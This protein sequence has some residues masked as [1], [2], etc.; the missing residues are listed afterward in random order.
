M[1]RLFEQ[2]KLITFDADDTLWDFAKML[3]RGTEAVAEAIARDHPEYAHLSTEAIIQVQ[4][5]AL[6][7][8]DP[9]TID[10]YNM[11][12]EAF[13]G[14]LHDCGHPTAAEYAHILLEAYLLARDSQYDFWPD[15][16]STLDALRGRFRL[17]YITNGT[18]HPDKVKL[19]DYFDVVVTPDTL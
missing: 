19:S 16:L 11:R 2:V 8:A 6:R 15:T 1:G 10:F 12:L 18:T 5:D 7:R 4:E 17:G 3:R 13:T 14:M 9:Q